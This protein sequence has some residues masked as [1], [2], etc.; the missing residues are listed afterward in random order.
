MKPATGPEVLFYPFHLCHQE[1]LGRL[2]R[3]FHA[4][5]FRDFMAL[6]LTPFSG[7]TAFHD[8]MGDSL[9]ELVSSGRLVQG[10]DVSGP[11]PPDVAAAIDHDLD[12]QVWRSLFHAALRADVRFQRGLFQ[13]PRVGHLTDD[14]LQ[15]D[16]YSIE[17]VRALSAQT[18]RPIREGDFEYGLALVKTSAS[19]VYTYRIALMHGLQVATDSSAHYS[20]LERS[21]RRELLSVGNHLLLRKGY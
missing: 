18:D 1:T 14:R 15:V 11:I 16:S 8:R 6:Q 20:L 21:C 19:L 13:V 2:L 9:P 3:R 12:D 7:M 10:Y 4:V 17:R 5:H